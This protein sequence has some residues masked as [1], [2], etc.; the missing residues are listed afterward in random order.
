MSIAAIIL[1]YNE[2]D[3]TLECASKLSDLDRSDLKIYLVDNGSTDGSVGKL[4]SSPYSVISTGENL[5]FAGGMN[6]GIKTAMDDGAEYIWLLNN[7][8]TFPENFQLDEL[9]EP[10]EGD[11]GVVSPLVREPNGRIWFS[12]GELDW[13]RVN[14]RN[15]DQ[16]ISGITETPH[17]PLAAALINAEVLRKVRLP[18]GYFMYW[19]D[20]EWAIRVQDAGYRLVT[21]GGVEVIHDGGASSN[22]ALKSYYT[23]RNRWILFRQYKGRFGRFYVWYL[24]TMLQLSAGRLLHQEINALI[25]LWT[26]VLDGVLGNTGRGRYP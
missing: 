26:G 16:P 1:N 8:I 4:R 13:E 2:P 5:G 25:A 6:W 12:Q 19:E 9:L 17:M 10:I 3:R 20:V 14:A 24:W 15:L 7:D 22:E 23:A 21:H 11:I 18:E